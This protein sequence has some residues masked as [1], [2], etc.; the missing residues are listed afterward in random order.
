MPARQAPGSADLEQ[1]VT[2]VLKLARDLGASQAEASASFGT[3]FSVNV[4]MR[5][6]ET[7]RHQRD[8]GLGVTVYLGQ[9]RGSPPTRASPTPRARR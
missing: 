3:G 5:E 7:I 2:D 1:R 9:R 6:V 4:R 8:Q